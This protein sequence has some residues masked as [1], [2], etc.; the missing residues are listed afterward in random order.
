[1]TEPQQN[2]QPQQRREE[3]KRPDE[4]DDAAADAAAAS[5]LAT[6]TEPPRKLGSAHSTGMEASVL[7]VKNVNFTVGQGDRSKQI[8]QDI[9]VKIR[10]GH[11]LARK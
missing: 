6:T 2:P 9:T 8:L 10:W 11:V 4:E 7:R 5:V 1:M 3:E